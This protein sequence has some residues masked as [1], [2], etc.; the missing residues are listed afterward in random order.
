M[1]AN[2]AAK[3]RDENSWAEM[4]WEISESRGKRE[5]KPLT[6]MVHNE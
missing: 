2:S 6:H 4:K 3:R 1:K 5:K